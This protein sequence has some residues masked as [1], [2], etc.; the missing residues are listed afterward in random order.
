MKAFLNRICPLGYFLNEHVS[1]FH[2]FDMHV[3]EYIMRARKA[4]VFDGKLLIRVLRS[5]IVGFLLEWIAHEID[6][7]VVGVDVLTIW[8]GLQCEDTVANR[9]HWKSKKVDEA[10]GN[11]QMTS[12]LAVLRRNKESRFEA[13][14]VEASYAPIQG[15]RIDICMVKSGGRVGRYVIY[16]GLKKLL[17][18]HDGMRVIV[19]ESVSMTLGQVFDA[20]IMEFAKMSEYEIASVRIVY[21][22][23]E[24][25]G[26]E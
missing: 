24:N 1:D 22:N 3:V 26:E 17:R 19:Y 10:F 8:H 4:A 21:S 23:E 13:A 2:V 9:M 7:H 16:H 25:L 6:T 20:F 11:V 5:M 14:A 15:S 18:I 12:R